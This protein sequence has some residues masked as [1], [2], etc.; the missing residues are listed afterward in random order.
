MVR[1]YAHNLRQKLEHYYATDG[2]RRDAADFARARRVP[3]VARQARRCPSR[4]PSR[5]AAGRSRAVA[6]VPTASPPPRRARSGGLRSRPCR[7]S[8]SASCSGLRS[9]RCGRPRP[10]CRRPSRHSPCGR[11]RIRRRRA[12]SRG[13]RRLLHLRRARRARRRR[14]LGSRFRGELQQ[15]AR[16]ANHVRRRAARRATWISTSRICRAARAFAL[17]DVLRVLYTVEKPV[18]IV[19]MSE[20]NVADLKSNH[21]VY[22]GYIS[23]LDKLEDFVFASSTLTVGDTYDELRNIE[24]DEMYTSEAGCRRSSATTAT[25]DS[26][27]R[28]PGPGGN[29]FVIIAGMRDA[30]MMQAAHA[31]SDPMFIKSVEHERARWRG[32]RA[33]VRDALRS[34]G[35]GR[36]NLD[37]M[38]VYTAQARTTSRSGAATSCTATDSS[39]R[40]QLRVRQ[41]HLREHAA[42]AAAAV[43]LDRRRCPRRR[44]RRALRALASCAASSESQRRRRQRDHRRRRPRPRSSSMLPANACELLE[45]QVDD[46]AAARLEPL[47]HAERCA[48]SVNRARAQ[49]R[50][51]SADR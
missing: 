37:A 25:T 19:S 29:Q 50:E 31:L 3:N 12:D 45:A 23:A 27:R 16:R 28:F 41:R 11:S 34:H 44:A 9:T 35:L 33:R 8:C 2:T 20:L 17:L 40:R 38:L 21:V 26:S 39:A 47:E 7:C 42:H 30:G 43:F 32:R 5:R 15:G 18:R 14:A 13:G 51:A 1:V 48:G 4:R 24:T 36:T 49:R 46:L 22:L 6:V 10:R